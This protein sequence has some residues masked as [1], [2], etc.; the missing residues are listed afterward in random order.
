[1]GDKTLAQLIKAQFPGEYDEYDDRELEDLIIAKYPGEY[2]DY[3]RSTPAD[4][5]GAMIKETGSQL[6]EGAK[7][8]AKGALSGIT[9][10]ADA[11]RRA[12]PWTKAMDVDLGGSRENLKPTNTA[13]KVGAFVGEVGLSAIPAVRGAQGVAMLTRG[14]PAA[15]RL[16][17]QAAAG[18]ATNAAT[19]QAFGHESAKT[20]AIVGAAGPVAGGLATGAATLASKAAVPLARAALKTPV[21]M[22]RRAYPDATQKG[23]DRIA[24]RLA[25]TTLNNRLFN[26]D[27]ATA[28]ID[29]DMSAVNKGLAAKG[30]VPTNAATREYKAV[31]RLGRR[32]QQ[33]EATEAY[34]GKVS[35]KLD[36]ILRGR[37]GTDIETFTPDKARTA[38][39]I[40]QPRA[41]PVDDTIEATASRVPQSREHIGFQRALPANTAEALPAGPSAPKHGRHAPRPPQ[42]GAGARGAQGVADAGRHR[43][44]VEERPVLGRGRHCANDVVGEA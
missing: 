7:G 41:A 42:D 1:M 33:G 18:A 40:F 10:A 29:K 30:D 27:V 16:G 39:P 14:M 11:I 22:L 19:G 31:Q 5:G 23:L 20:D 26:E 34:Q 32:A 28:A 21:A 43:P 35:D 24:N 37:F 4:W 12:A 44:G 8:V 9:G 2:D 6:L 38:A 3:P 15:V 36:E 17:G 25:N 13:Q